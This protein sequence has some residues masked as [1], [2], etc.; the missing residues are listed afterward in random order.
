M[1]PIVVVRRRPSGWIQ[2]TRCGCDR[3]PVG[4]CAATGPQRA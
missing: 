1:A 4:R 2:A 3:E